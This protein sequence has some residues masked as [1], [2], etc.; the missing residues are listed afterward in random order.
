MQTLKE[1]ILTDLYAIL[2]QHTYTSAPDSFEIR[3]IMA[4]AL[5]QY[6]HLNF[7]KSVPAPRHVKDVEYEFFHICANVP[8]TQT[9]FESGFAL[10]FDWHMCELWNKGNAVMDGVAKAIKS[11]KASVD[12]GNLNIA[13]APYE[14][15]AIAG[16]AKQLTQP[17][18][19]SEI[20][21]TDCYI[22]CESVEERGRI[23][24]ML[25]LNGCVCV[26]AG[27]AN[28][29]VIGLDNAKEYGIHT[30]VPFTLPTYPASMF[31][32]DN[33]NTIEAAGHSH[34]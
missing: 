26:Y 32:G 6:H 2:Y 33:D 18:S 10:W 3:K 11:I 24:H 8:C 34:C 23:R 21:G 30:D 4:K 31:F 15:V 17:R 29:L 9:Q 12:A 5:L 13:G 14:V 28:G 22:K 19:L 7:A 25:D 1:T 16:T 20:I 27:N